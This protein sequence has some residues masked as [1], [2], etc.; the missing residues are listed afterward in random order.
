MAGA[1]QLLFGITGR[2][3]ETDHA[4]KE[5]SEKVINE[6]WVRPDKTETIVNGKRVENACYW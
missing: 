3:W 1:T 6:Y 2:R 4:Y 5:F